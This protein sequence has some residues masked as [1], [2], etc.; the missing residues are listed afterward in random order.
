MMSGTTAKT[1]AQK[2]AEMIQNSIDDKQIGL[3]SGFNSVYIGEYQLFPDEKYPA[4][5][6]TSD[7]HSFEVNGNKLAIER[8][9]MLYCHA[10]MPT[11]EESEEV[12]DELLFG[13]NGQGNKGMV[14]FLVDNPRFQV[15]GQFYLLQFT[16]GRIKSGFDQKS[17]A[18]AQA[19]IPLKVV[20]WM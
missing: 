18:T 20:I 14:K 3:L 13:D 19:E 8:N 9:I 10:I 1:P 17:R 4:I 16:K 5:T 2:I 15:A 6:L 11:L 12:L 7:E